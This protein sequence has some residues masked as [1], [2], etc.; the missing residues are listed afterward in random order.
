MNIKAAWRATSCLLLL[1]ISSCA[2]DQMESTFDCSIS[3]VQVELLETSETACG[4]ANGAFSLGV[5]GGESPYTF[6]S[7]AGASAEGLFENIG[8]GSYT[9]QVTDVNGC[10]DE[11]TVEVLN[12]DGVNLDN[13]LTTD[14]GCQTSQGTVEITASGG[15]EPYLYSID[16]GNTQNS[17]TFSG[18]AGGTHNISIEDQEGCEITTSVKLTSGVKFSTVEGIIKNRCTSCHG[19]SASPSFGSFEEISNKASRIMARTSAGTM[20]PSGSL[21]QSEIDA[22]AC[23]VNDGALSN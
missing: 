18:L 13:I 23:W 7:E 6:S 2:W 15:T 20:P 17:N 5:S 22:I 21:P 19:S 4:T 16:G 8:A 12:S 1:G 9:V 11:I 14:A 3:P 10:S